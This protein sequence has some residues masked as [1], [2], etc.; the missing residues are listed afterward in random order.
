[1]SGVATWV[2]GLLVRLGAVL[3][4]AW[5]LRSLG[6]GD[7]AAFVLALLLVVSVEPDSRA[8]QALRRRHRNDRP[9]H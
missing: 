2:I 9:V 4:L 7:L 3:G 6:L 1:M 5:I 8:R